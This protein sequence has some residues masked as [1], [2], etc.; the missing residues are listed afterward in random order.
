MAETA[1]KALQINGFEFCE[2]CLQ[3]DLAR[4][5]LFPKDSELS[6]ELKDFAARLTG[7][8]QWRLK[9]R[10]ACVLEEKLCPLLDPS[11]SWLET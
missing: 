9:N 2:L 1:A 7:E 8:M 4:T 6:E 3:G 10:R 5:R 11:P